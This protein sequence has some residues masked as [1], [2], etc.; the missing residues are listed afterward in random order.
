MIR[1][2]VGPEPGEPFIKRGT[3]VTTTRRVTQGVTG[4]AARPAPLHPGAARGVLPEGAG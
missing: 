3:P 1:L 2:L 4:R